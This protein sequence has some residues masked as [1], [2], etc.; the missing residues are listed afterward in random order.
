M[1]PPGT[2]RPKK[3]KLVKKANVQGKASAAPAKPTATVA[4]EAQGDEEDPIELEERYHDYETF[5]SMTVIEHEIEY[6]SLIV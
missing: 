4:D 3:K 5:T 1:Y 2:E 6:L